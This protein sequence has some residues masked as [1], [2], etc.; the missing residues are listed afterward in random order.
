M[1]MHTKKYL[2]KLLMI[3]SANYKINKDV[4]YFIIENNEKFNLTLIN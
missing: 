3:K 2:C 1:T 4:Y